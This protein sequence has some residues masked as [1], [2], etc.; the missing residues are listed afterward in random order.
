MNPLA[1]PT[2]ARPSPG[3][4]L[5]G[6]RLRRWLTLLSVLAAGVLLLL[7]EL[8]IC[9]TA[10]IAG[11]PCPG[12]GLTRATFALLRGDV[13][14]AYRYHPLVFVLAPVYVG[15]VLWCAYRFVRGGEG[16]PTSR[17]V[18]RWI[19]RGALVLLVLLLGVW[20][21]RF[22]GLFGGPVPVQTLEDW[23]RQRL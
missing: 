11:V 4:P 9:P 19:T 3:A 21:L 15:T 1:P 10:A 8:P 17:H 6:E 22:G 7:V 5:G 2:A 13:Q 16:A 18:D 20:L 23:W 12:C 14:Q